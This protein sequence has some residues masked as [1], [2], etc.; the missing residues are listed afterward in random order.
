MWREFI[1]FRMPGFWGNEIEPF[2]RKTCKES[3]TIN[4][5]ELIANSK[6]VI[7]PSRARSYINTP[8]FPHQHLLRKPH[9]ERGLFMDIQKIIHE[10]LWFIDGHKSGLS[11]KYYI[12]L[13]SSCASPTPKGVYLW[14]FKIIIHEHLWLID[15]HF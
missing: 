14:T 12:L 15:G 6:N 8:L 7:F 5:N 1:P 10:H 3:F 11:I 2:S 4:F 13:R 9:P